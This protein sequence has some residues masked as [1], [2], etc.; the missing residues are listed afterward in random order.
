MANANRITWTHNGREIVSNE[1]KIIL[2]S[3]KKKQRGRYECNGYDD[4]GYSFIAKS[5]V[6]FY[7]EFIMYKGMNPFKAIV[8]HFDPEK[9]YK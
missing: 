9:L 5:D 6:Y 8:G 2:S 1:N 7:S 4:Y 3:F